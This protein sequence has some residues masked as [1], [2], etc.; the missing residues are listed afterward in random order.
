MILL[1]TWN[2]LEKR[3]SYI[4]QRVRIE[5]K[6]MSLKSFSLVIW[7]MVTFTSKMISIEN[8]FSSNFGVIKP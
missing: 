2:N 5:G 1:P 8:I 3:T 4:F 7:F 6:I